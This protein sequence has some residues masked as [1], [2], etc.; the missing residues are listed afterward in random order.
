[1]SAGLTPVT[2]PVHPTVVESTTGENSTEARPVEAHSGGTGLSPPQPADPSVPIDPSDGGVPT[3]LLVLGLAHR[4]GTV[5]GSELYQVAA[6]CG[7]PPETVRS[8]LRRL[9]ADGLFERRGSGRNAVFPPTATGR[10]LLEVNEQRHLLAWAQD[11]A[12]RG[13]DRRWRLVAFAIPETRRGARDAFRDHLRSL[14]GAPIQ[15]GLYVSPHRWQGEVSAEA[16]RLGIAGFVSQFSTDDLSVNGERDPR[17][18]ATTL[19]PLETVAARYERFI[20]T[21]RD[22]PHA[23]EAMRRRGEKL[24]EH[25]FLP[26]AL[27]IAIRF[28]ECFESDPLLPPELLPRPWPGREARDLLA[29][30]RRIGVLAREDRGGPAL[31]RVFDE[32]IAHLP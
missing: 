2:H 4:D 24:S 8:C 29:R 13:W 12:G 28:N 14:G 25:D 19:W 26:G 15:P 7:I 6:E 1:M 32:A 18:L 17:A 11:A 30:C 10:Q 31:F 27:H 22:V 21:Y 16:D 3:R 23:L 20:E 5:H 9:V